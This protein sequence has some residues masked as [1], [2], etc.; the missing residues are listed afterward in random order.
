MYFS[1][2]NKNIKIIKKQ[3]KNIIKKNKNLIREKVRSFYFF[4]I[5]KTIN[6]ALIIYL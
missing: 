3:I 6:I 1:K 5:K 2:N 4:Y